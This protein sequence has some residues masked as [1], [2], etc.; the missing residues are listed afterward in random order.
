MLHCA[1]FTGAL[2]RTLTRVPG[3]KGSGAGSVLFDCK[4]QTMPPSKLIL[5]GKRLT[6]KRPSS[7]LKTGGLLGRGPFNFVIK[8][9]NRKEFKP[10][11]AVG[12]NTV[13]QLKRGS[14]ATAKPARYLIEHD[15]RVANCIIP[16]FS[17]NLLFRDIGAGHANNC[18]P[19]GFNETIGGLTP[20]GSSNYA[21]VFVDMTEGFATDELLIKISMEEPDV[22]S[23]YID[24]DESVAEAAQ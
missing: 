21:A 23:C 18:F 4:P 22:A 12:F 1:T 16:K 11:R 5:A 17:T 19:G 3:G 2:T 9:T 13:D 24:E 14:K 10:G 8:I 15:R 20:G 6:G 7:S